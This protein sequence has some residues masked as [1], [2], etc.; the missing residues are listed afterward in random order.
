MFDDGALQIATD[1][2]PPLDRPGC[3]PATMPSFAQTCR[4]SP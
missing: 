2:A 1:I 4:V 3:G